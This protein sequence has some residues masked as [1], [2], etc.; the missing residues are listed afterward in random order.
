[1]YEHHAQ[2][3]L[4]RTAFWRRLIWH[5]VVSSLV[6][7]GALLIG[8]AGYRFIGH[9]T[10]IDA[11]VE[12]AMLMSGMG[13]VYSAQMVTSSA[14]LFAGCYALFAGLVFMIAFGILLAPILHRFLHKFHLDQD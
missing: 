13:P 8:M 10:W 2:P 6:V 11:F 3:L 4:H 7:A 9:L 12:S 5:F 1:M 14:K